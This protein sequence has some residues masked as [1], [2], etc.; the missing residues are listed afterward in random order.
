MSE[1]HEAAERRSFAAEQARIGCACARAEHLNVL[2][3]THHYLSR[4]RG[5][6]QKVCTILSWKPQHEIADQLTQS[7]YLY[8]GG[9]FLGHPMVCCSMPHPDSFAPIRWVSMTHIGRLQPSLLGTTC[10]RCNTVDV[11]VEEHR[12]IR[13]FFGRYRKLLSVPSI[14]RTQQTCGFF[15]PES[16]ESERV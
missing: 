6:R 5:Y 3:V 1:T 13:F 8:V 2:R 7:I 10:W 12:E 9:D 4:C 16:T 11:Q 15:I 14:F